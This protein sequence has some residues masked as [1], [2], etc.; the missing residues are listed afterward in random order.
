MNWVLLA[1]ALTVQG[2]VRKSSVVEEFE[3]RGECITKV[4]TM[5]RYPNIMY[6]CMAREGGTQ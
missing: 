5:V 6:V 3:T 4:N 1:M 2:E